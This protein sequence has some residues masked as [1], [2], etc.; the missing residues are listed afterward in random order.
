MHCQT[1]KHSVMNMYENALLIE[2]IKDGQRIYDTFWLHAMSNYVR[3]GMDHIKT[4]I[5]P[6]VNQPSVEIGKWQNIMS[7]INL[8]LIEEHGIQI[9]RRRAGGG[10]IYYDQGCL[11]LWFKAE[12]NQSGRNYFDLAT[13]PIVEALHKMGATEVERTGRNDLAIDGK[14]VSGTAIYT[15]ANYVGGGVSLLLDINYNLIDEILTPNMK[16]LESKGI[17]STRSR[18]TSLRPYLA[19][20]LQSVSMDQF[21]EEIL[22]HLFNVERYQDIPQ[23]HLTQED[24]DII[25]RDYLPGY[26]DWNWNFGASPKFNYNRDYHFPI[27]TI[28]FS[29]QVEQA[30]ITD[31]RIYGDFFGREDIT[32]IE[33]ALIGCRL[34]HQDLV[35]CFNQFNLSEYFGNVSSKQLADLILS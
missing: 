34:N 8:P 20:E 22:C 9:L 10:T 19:L 12:K 14:K 2:P 26:Q 21:R 30:R 27:G 1:S 15:K 23:Y 17:N 28:E 31:C 7:E 3:E 4:A 24:W 11:A 29:L 25:E 5:I 16:K 18:V 32:E 6:A 33:Q 35:Y 13:E